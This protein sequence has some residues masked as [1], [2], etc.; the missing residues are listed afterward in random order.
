M[1]DWFVEN[2]FNLLQTAA[3]VFS[4]FFAVWTLLL[5]QKKDRISNYISLVQSHRDLWR[6]LIEHPELASVA[7]GEASRS[8]DF[9]EHPITDLERRFAIFRILH[10]SMSYH[11]FR[12]GAL[13]DSPKFSDE[14]KASFKNEILKRVWMEIRSY[15]DSKFVAFIDRCIEK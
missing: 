12:Q 1:N 11:L 2:W 5:S 8:R 7:N 15:H 10:I 6:M 13:P 4:I 14:I 3:I 9:A